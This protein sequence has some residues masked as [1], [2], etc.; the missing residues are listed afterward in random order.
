[1]IIR[2]N[3]N[4]PPWFFGRYW[5][6]A[7]AR[8]IGG[9]RGILTLATVPAIEFW[10]SSAYSARQL[11]F[12]GIET[13]RMR[14]V[15]PVSAF[16]EM[17]R[18]E[19]A[20]ATGARPADSPIRILFVGRLVPNKGHKHL[21]AVSG[22]LK[23][24]LAREVELILPGRAYGE[25]PGYVPELI[26]LAQGLSVRLVLKGEVTHDAL[27]ALYTE[28]DAF[29]CL[30]EHEGF[31]LPVFEAMRMGLPVIGLRSTALREFLQEHPLAIGE[32]DYV[33]ITARIVAALHPA[34]RELVIGWQRE[35]LR[36][37]YSADI[38]RS[39]IADALA[40][41][42]QVSAPVIPR[43][44]ALE[45]RI[46]AIV[47]DWVP[48]LSNIRDRLPQL[49]RIPV[50][51]IDRYVT[52]HDIAAYDAL[53]LDS[54][55]SDLFAT[56]M[57]TKFTSPRPVI[58]PALRLVR[59]AALS[60]QTGL[61]TGLSLMDAR[62]N[63]RFDS[64]EHTISILQASIYHRSFVQKGSLAMS[65]ESQSDPLTK[66][67]DGSYGTMSKDEIKTDM[68]MRYE[69]GDAYPS[70][71]L[72]VHV[73]HTELEATFVELLRGKTKAKRVLE[74]G[75]GLGGLAV[76]NLHDVDMIVG[77]DLSESALCAARDFFRHQQRV[78]F[79]QMDAE[80]LQ[81]P[82]SSFDIV[83]AKE[84]LEHL[85]KPKSCMDEVH[86]V[87][88]S[89]GYFVLSSPNRD[90]L[91]L[92]VNRKLGRPDFVCA[93]DHI[94][95]FTYSE[96]TDL[97]TES[98]FCVETA[99]GVMLMPYHYVEGVFPDAVRAAED[100]DAECVDWL[101]VLGRR[102]GPEFAFGYVILAKKRD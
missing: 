61:L 101:R 35:L 25:M 7:V 70:S 71:A 49:H 53:T 59:R 58:G 37:F 84:L 67:Q 14:V 94:R 48:K 60:L 51:T 43:D 36:A 64:I 98:G 47:R 68:D 38:V 46:A 66:F 41:R 72:W 12:L 89:H 29:V 20:H 22:L 26:A 85:Q 90:S 50:D 87:L 39:Q 8:T 76:R 2:W 32:M 4:T 82:D 23:Q 33:E 28:C 16:L 40:R 55:T 15:Y 56:V 42:P 3:N 6:A 74:I 44:A 21:I 11:S 9:Y 86:R 97:L 73:H 34:V 57:A 102:A 92:R 63:R 62:V 31:G 96:M 52:R 5:K 88:S 13:D 17:S 24:A 18:R 54:Q 83:I 30:S 65:Q 45:A 79:K 100:T 10:P 77:T 91:H 99:E 1:V 75:C 80:T 81:F 95:E 78:E 69:T 19:P 27:V 93:G